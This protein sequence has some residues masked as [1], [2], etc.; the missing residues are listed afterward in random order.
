MLKDKHD[1]R[2]SLQGQHGTEI[3]GQVAN[4]RLDDALPPH[5]VKRWREVFLICFQAAQPVRFTSQMLI[6][7][8]A[9]LEG[10]ALLAPLGDNEARV[11]SLF[12]VF[13]SWQAEGFG[14]IRTPSG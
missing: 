13:V 14:G 2:I 10:E 12:V 6:G 7:G 9:W 11:Q 4:R 8:K 1:F 3:Y 5:V